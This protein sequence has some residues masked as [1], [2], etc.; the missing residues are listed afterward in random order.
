M[1]LSTPSGLVYNFMSPREFTS[2]VTIGRFAEGGGV[3]SCSSRNAFG[4]SQNFAT[5]KGIITL[6]INL[7]V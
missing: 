1:S 4:R 2:N 3:Y 5:V 7:N 6:R